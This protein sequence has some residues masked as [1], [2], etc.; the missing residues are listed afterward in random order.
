[1]DPF[2][3]WQVY[4][5][6]SKSETRTETQ[7]LLIRVEE[8]AVDVSKNIVFPHFGCIL[9]T[10]KND[11]SLLTEIDI[12]AHTELAKKLTQILDLPVLSEELPTSEQQ[13]ILNAECLSYWCI[14]PIDGTSNY[15]A[16]I[17]YW[18]V[19]I[20]LIINGQ[21]ELGV[22]YDANRNECFSATTSCAT[23]L[24]K[25]PLLVNEQKRTVTELKDCMAMIDFKRL[26]PTIAQKIV[27]NPPYRSQR[28]FGAGALDLCWVAAERC[29]LYLHG[30]QKLWDHAAGLLILY[31]SGGQAETFQGDSVFKN[32]LEPKSVLATSNELLMKK[33]KA[34]Y[35]ELITIQA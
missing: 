12:Q 3:F 29:Q 28:S 17:P 14:D 19:S 24:N 8:L 33:W 20:A 25:R 23:M 9:E 26:Q 11:G 30:Q 32:N 27:A 13:A 22:V 18:C 2:S 21:V 5:K 34:Y 35:Q 7:N 1:M 15:V 16:G 10:K 31:Q 6:E 4:G